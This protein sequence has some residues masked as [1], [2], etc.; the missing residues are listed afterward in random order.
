MDLCDLKEEGEMS[1]YEALQRLILHLGEN[2]AINQNLEG[3]T[4]EVIKNL[5]EEK[6]PNN[7]FSR[8]YL[9]KSIVEQ[10]K[11]AF[12]SFDIFLEEGNFQENF[13]NP[14]I[15]EKSQKQRNRIFNQ[16][17]ESEEFKRLFSTKDLI[18][19]PVQLGKGLNSFFILLPKLASGICFFQNPKF[20]YPHFTFLNGLFSD[21]FKQLNLKYSSQIV[22]S[23]QPKDIKNELKNMFNYYVFSRVIYMKDFENTLKGVPSL[24]WCTRKIDISVKTELLA[25]YTILRFIEILHPLLNVSDFQTLRFLEGFINFKQYENLLENLPQA[26][27]DDKNMIQNY[28]IYHSL[29]RC[30]NLERCLQK[31]MIFGRERC[32]DVLK[33]H[34][35][36]YPQLIGIWSNT[37][38]IDQSPF[39]LNRGNFRKFKKILRELRLSMP[40]NLKRTFKRTRRKEKC[41]IC[42]RQNKFLIQE[43]IEKLSDLQ[44]TTNNE[45][46]DN[47]ITSTFSVMTIQEGV[48]SNTPYYPVTADNSA[49]TQASFNIQPYQIPQ[50]HILQV[51]DQQHFPLQLNQV[52]RHGYHL[53]PVQPP[54]QAGHILLPDSHN[55]YSYPLF[56]HGPPA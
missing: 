13:I 16:A 23:K 1:S 20:P 14:Y 36:L 54:V 45:Y 34:L 51:Q 35:Y 24:G 6:F 37:Q 46:H 44:I 33:D 2:I 17:K 39:F 38:F 41:V 4:K 40:I 55:Y 32:W 56:L 10:Y 47:D 27:I 3:E 28:E 43:N 15:K 42:D 9:L 26:S 25:K 50:L 29:T 12:P 22:Y 49:L 19:I 53:V 5:Y 18:I 7:D 8:K 31:C 11:G 21:H 48:I 52:E 30:K